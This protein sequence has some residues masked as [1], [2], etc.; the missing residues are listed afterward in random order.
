MGSQVALPPV[1]TIAGT[2]LSID[3]VAPGE[4]ETTDIPLMNVVSVNVAENVDEYS[5]FIGGPLGTPLHIE[6]GELVQGPTSTRSSTRF[7]SMRSR[8]S[9][10]TRATT[11]SPT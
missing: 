8:S 6:S 10:R 1:T 3:A 9:A 5:M 7:R 4:F 2:P 11:A